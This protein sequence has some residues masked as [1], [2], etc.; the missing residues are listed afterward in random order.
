MTGREVLAHLGELLARGYG[1]QER[2]TRILDTM[3]VTCIV[4]GC[5]DSSPPRCTSWPP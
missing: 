1:M 2:I 4:L 3:E 5:G